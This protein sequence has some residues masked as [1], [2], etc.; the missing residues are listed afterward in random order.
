MKVVTFNIRCDYGQDGKNCFDH[1]KPLILEKIGREEPDVLCFQEVLPHV[2]IW[3]REN[4]KD[5]YVIGCGRG[6]AL[7]DEQMT[8]AY[9]RD[10]FNLI[11]MRTFWLSETP[12]VPGSRYAEQSVCPRSTTEA[13]LQE[14]ATGRVFRV[15]NTHLDHV[16]VEARKLGLSQILRHIDA[17]EL[18]PD[19]PTI[20]CGDFNAEPDG[21][22]L[23][24][25][26]D[27]P[28]YVNATEGV[29]VTFHGYMLEAPE[30][31]DYIYLRGGVRS[32]GVEKWT[33]MVDGV[34]LSD[35]YPICASLA[36]TQPDA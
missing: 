13:L 16:G 24:V 11:E 8:V 20:L 14:Y 19:A 3:L 7:D 33:D 6:E 29:G 30:R 36:W 10:R 9:R 1:R 31:I 25:F 21:E 34:Y 12:G 18:F 27:F 32:E 35:H 22:E 23:T 26:D 28:G 5:Y 4:L 15:I 2:A 17:A